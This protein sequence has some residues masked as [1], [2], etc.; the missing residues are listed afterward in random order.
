[1]RLTNEDPNFNFY[2]NKSLKVY[3]CYFQELSTLHIFCYCF[4]DVS[5]FVEQ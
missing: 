4:L 2:V 1:M 3:T 5:I